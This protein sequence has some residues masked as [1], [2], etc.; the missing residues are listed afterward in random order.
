[1]NAMY[2]TIMTVIRINLTYLLVKRSNLVIIAI[3]RK[4]SSILYVTLQ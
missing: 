3:L 2:D 4:K 1:M